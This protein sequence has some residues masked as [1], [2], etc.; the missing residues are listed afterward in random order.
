[1]GP[2]F[3]ERASEN[4]SAPF[5]LCSTRRQGP[6]RAISGPSFEKFGDMRS[7]EMLTNWLLCATINAADKRELTLSSEPIGRSGSWSMLVVPLEICRR[8]LTETS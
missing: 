3:R 8:G 2:W 7:C 5:V 1:M 6:L 4:D